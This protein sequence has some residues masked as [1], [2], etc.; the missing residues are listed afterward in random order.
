MCSS[1]VAFDTALHLKCGLAIP[2]ESLLVDSYGVD[3]SIERGKSSSEV[4]VPISYRRSDYEKPVI[5][6]ITPDEIPLCRYHTS[7]R[8]CCV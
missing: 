8:L 6:C 1:L 4:L 2:E 5:S 7:R 3:Y